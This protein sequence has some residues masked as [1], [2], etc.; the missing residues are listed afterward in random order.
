MS[1][2]IIELN[3]ATVRVAR[4]VEPLFQSPGYATTVDGVLAVGAGGYAQH[5]LR[6]RHASNRF[7]HDLNTA[8]LQQFGKRVR[9]A[10]DLAFLHLEHL[11]ECAGHPAAAIFIVPGFY[12]RPQLSLLLGIA[13]AA[14]IGVQAL[15]DSA[16]AVG[17]T[18]PPGTY[19]HVEATLHQCVISHLEVDQE[20]AVRRQVE[21]VA[22]AGLAHFKQHIVSCVVDAFLTR[23]RFDPLHDAATEQLLHDHLN[24]WLALLADRPEITIAIEHRG[25]R[26]ETRLH[27]DTVI[28]ATRPLVQ[29]LASRVGDA[30]TVLDY[31]LGVIPGVLYGWR[32]AQL[33]TDAAVLVGCAQNPAL[34]SRHANT[35]VALRTELP[36]VP[37]DSRIALTPSAAN[38]AAA[39]TASHLLAQHV[40]YPIGRRR[41][42]VAPHGAV[43][44]TR[45]I[46]S[47]CVVHGDDTGTRLEV[48]NSATVL[49]NGRAVAG[50][51]RLNP[52][53]HITIPG[54]TSLFVPITVHANDAI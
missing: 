15:V 21:V 41:L 44:R 33:L 22:G 27:R 54:A 46:D 47:V 38:D 34:K 26:H 8:P 49:L 28:A 3:D 18:L 45:G 30:R 40:A 20:R 37:A 13:Q 36:V 9:H 5:W 16:A 17:A 50:T 25:A 43:S 48:L 42:Y 1:A 52:G 24:E 23:C 6:P 12:Q 51:A 2:T 7:W 10:G 35:S 32:D 19:A 11:R 4:G 39:S 29:Q 14:G 31:R 53:D